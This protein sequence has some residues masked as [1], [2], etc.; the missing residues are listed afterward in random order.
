M[1]PKGDRAKMLAAL[2]C[3]SHVL[4]FEDDTPDTILRALRPDFLVKGGTYALDEVVGRDIV[5]DYGGR[6]AV[7]SLVDGISTT[8]IIRDMIENRG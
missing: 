2:G 8:K 3:V 6:V 5:H 1:I 7:V 4:I